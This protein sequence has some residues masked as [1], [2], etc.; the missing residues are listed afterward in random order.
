MGVTDARSRPPRAESDARPRSRSLAAT[1][2]VLDRHLPAG[3]IGPPARAALDRIGAR[4]PAALTRR[5]Y[6]ECRLRDAA[7]QVDVIVCVDRDTR[8]VLSDAGFWL[9]GSLRGHPWWN[10]IA[11]VTD[12]WQDDRSPLSAGIYDAWLEF[13]A[14]EPSGSALIP[15]VFV[16]LAAT[17][18]TPLAD[19]WSVGRAAVAVILD[20]PV[21]S[22]IVR[23]AERCLNCLPAGAT[24]AYVGLMYP[25]DREALRLCV[26][27]LHGAGLLDYLAAIGW[28]GPVD[29]LAATLRTIRAHEQRC[30]L[31][32]TTLVH[33]DLREEVGPRIGLEIY[34]DQWPQILDGVVDDAMLNSLCGLG[35]CTPSKRDA[36][37]QWCGHTVEQFP[38]ACWPSLV[39]RRVSHVKVVFGLDGAP[40]AKAYLSVFHGF[41]RHHSTLPDSEVQR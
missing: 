37:V 22:E 14:D 32:A 39:L 38:H 36:L 17:H 28:P 33:L 21:N 35:L 18:S 41:S 4:L 26:A 3:L 8:R 34:F 19:L 23:T 25:R 30:G 9:P 15:S 13:D 1:F 11:R 10:G 20:R 31:E 27:P 24:L 7:P 12:Q 5:L 2:D 29:R 16:G 6:F 40:E